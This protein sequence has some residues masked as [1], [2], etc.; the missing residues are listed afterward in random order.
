[1]PQRDFRLLEKLGEGPYGSWSRAVDLSTSSEVLLCHLRE[2]DADTLATVRA[3]MVRAADVRHPFVGRPIELVAQGDAPQLVF[4]PIDGLPLDRVLRVQGMPVRVALEL[5]RKVARGLSA[6]W[7]RVPSGRL[8]ALG[9][10]HGA[11][12]PAHVWVA[13]SGQ[14][15]VFGLWSSVTAPPVEERDPIYSAPEVLDGA[16]SHA[17]DVY[18]LGAM[19]CHAITGMAPDAAGRT[20]DEHGVLVAIV[21]EMVGEIANDPVLV[22]LIGRMMAFDPAERPAAAEVEATIERTRKEREEPRTS[23][24][25]EVTI[26]RVRAT[27]MADRPRTTRIA[28]I[29]RR[30]QADPAIRLDGA[31]PSG[32]NPSIPPLLPEEE[33]SVEAATAPAEVEPVAAEPVAEE[34]APEP[35][36]AEPEP[37]AAEP[38]PEP[39]AAELEPE[40]EPVVTEPEPVA[41]EPEL[42]AARPRPTA[43]GFAAVDPPEAEDTEESSGDWTVDTA[44]ATPVTEE[45]PVWAAVLTQ[46]QLGK[47]RASAITRRMFPDP[48]DIDE[49]FGAASGPDEDIEAGEAPEGA[50]DGLEAME[51]EEEEEAAAERTGVWGFFMEEGARADSGYRA[52]AVQITE[53]RSPTLKRV[54]MERYNNDRVTTYEGEDDVFVGGDEGEDSD[55][56]F[57]GRKAILDRDRTQMS[58]I[59]DFDAVDE[60]AEAPEGLEPEPFVPVR[61]KIEF[62]SGRPRSPNRAE[63]AAPGPRK[64]TLPPTPAED[65]VGAPLFPRVSEP[66]RGP[67]PSPAQ[68]EDPSASG[69]LMPNRTSPAKVLENVENTLPGVRPRPERHTGLHRAPSAQGR[70]TGLDP[71]YDTFERPTGNIVVPR[72]LWAPATTK[73]E[74]EPVP[75]ELRDLRG[76]LPKATPTPATRPA[77]T[78]PVARPAPPPPAAAPA[79]A[80][81]RETSSVIGVA[82]L[83]VTLVALLWRPWEGGPPSPS[84]PTSAPSSLTSSAPPPTVPVEPLA[85]VAVTPPP[86]PEPVDV[87]PA[88]ATMVAPTPKASPPPTP[89][90]APKAK[91]PPPAPVVAAKVKEPPP[92]APVVVAKAKEPPPAPAVAAKT[93]EPPPAPL[94]AAKTKEPPPAPLVA[95]KAK[96]P[97]PTSVSAVAPPVEAAK[98][99]PVGT[100]KVAGDAQSVRL[101]GHGKSLASGE[102]PVGSYE[103]KVVYEPGTEPVT[104]GQVTVLEGQQVLVRCSAAFMRCDVR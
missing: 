45:D 41:A 14:V 4:E 55:E 40:P 56:G 58:P 78:P 67:T 71:L 35:V 76:V 50:A 10:L 34:A 63:P 27:P 12:S 47:A 38:E 70:A 98:T 18:S 17:A 69:I 49:L 74:R 32:A 88:A 54:E 21:T 94:V 31:A 26:P 16:L 57:G 75:H 89:V 43:S 73:D 29:T 36:A 6:A 48:S 13:R 82:I 39:V 59:P 93:K 5:M 87:Q 100:F 80:G 62:L 85:P 61:S 83:A 101:I 3:Q 65:R 102:V 95:P 15:R 77:V 7:D 92:P 28:S 68:P 46:E 33:P 9:L 103:I 81:A 44:P 1:M 22:E 24:W 66:V 79:A 19:L 52:A 72:S 60:P 104:A 25:C 30:P 90:V 96:E 53:K 20:A 64:P 2:T 23:D 91:E 51:A 11:L 42:R 84:A 99:S 8:Q 97:P 37:V 86:T